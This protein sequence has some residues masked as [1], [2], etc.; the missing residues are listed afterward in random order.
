[1]PASPLD[2]GKPFSERRYLIQ[3]ALEMATT[4]AATLINLKTTPITSA[5]NQCI[6]TIP[7]VEKQT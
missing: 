3:R 2:H 1:M 4:I 6:N 7:P 5:V